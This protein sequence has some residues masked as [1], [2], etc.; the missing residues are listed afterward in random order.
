MKR[1]VALIFSFVSC[2]ALLIPVSAA[3]YSLSDETKDFYY[4]QY[5]EIAEQINAELGANISVN[6]KADFDESD[7]IA[8]DEFRKIATAITKWNIICD[9]DAPATRSIAS[10]TKEDTITVDNK[11]YTIAVTGRFTTMLVGSRQVFDGIDLIT[12]KAVGGG[13][14]NQTGYDFDL[15]DSRRTYSITVSG[16]FKIAQ[17]T[18][19]NKLVSVDFYCSTTGVVT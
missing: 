10:A 16:T 2:V 3:N 5:Q 17:A 18:F 12:S 9:E 19:R 11:T 15:I 7:W 8:P 1:F 4:T 13:T 6:P 14:W